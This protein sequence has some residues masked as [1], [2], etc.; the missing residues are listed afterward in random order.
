[1]EGAKCGRRNV[2]IFVARF[3]LIRTWA[4]RL[5]RN[6]R[7]VAGLKNWCYEGYFRDYFTLGLGCCGSSLLSLAS[8]LESGHLRYIKLQVDET[9]NGYEIR[10]YT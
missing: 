9:F 7:L 8:S 2:T 10:S 6:L 5:G 1:V 4:A 3:E